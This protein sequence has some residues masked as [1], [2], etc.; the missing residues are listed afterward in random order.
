MCQQNDQPLV[1]NTCN[2]F[3][4]DGWIPSHFSAFP[5]QPAFWTEGTAITKQED[6]VVSVM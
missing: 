6:L 4:C 3:Y 5:N 1:I 2:G